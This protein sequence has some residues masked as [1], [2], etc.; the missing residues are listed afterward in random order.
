MLW[1]RSPRVCTKAALTLALACT[2]LWLWAGHFWCKIT[3]SLKEKT[4][5]LAHVRLTL[6][7]LCSIMLTTA[8]VIQNGNGLKH[9]CFI[10]DYFGEIL[11]TGVSQN[12]NIFTQGQTLKIHISFLFLIN[13]VLCLVAQSCPTLCDPMDCSP[14]DSSVHGDSPD[15]NTGVGCHVLLEIFPTQG[16]NPGLTHCRQILYHLSQGSP[17]ILE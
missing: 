8:C 13:A 10:M 11:N 2:S 4:M 6:K 5:F 17:G 7:N 15:K 12:L 3:L 14:P 9:C 16:S 1:N